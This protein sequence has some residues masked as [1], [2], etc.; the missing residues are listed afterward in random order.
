M[1]F[2]CNQASKKLFPIETA[3]KIFKL[4]KL[5]IGNS[6][7]KYKINLLIAAYYKG[8]HWILENLHPDTNIDKSR[9]KSRVGGKRCL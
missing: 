9:N 5:F 1:F 3:W 7:R 8:L 6:N 2:N 4:L